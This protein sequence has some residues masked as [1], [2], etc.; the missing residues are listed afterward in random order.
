[1]IKVEAVS[2]PTAEF[3]VLS[4]KVA[5]KSTEVI[6]LERLQNFSK[7]V[8]T[9]LPSLKD[10]WQEEGKSLLKNLEDC[11]GRDFCGMEPDE[12]GYFDET[13]T[14]AR[15]SQVRL[16]ELLN[17]AFEETQ[18]SKFL[19]EADVLNSFLL[20]GNEKLIENSLKQLMAK[21]ILKDSLNKLN[22]RSSAQAIMI[23]SKQVSKEELVSLIEQSLEGS[24]GHTVISVFE[25]L[26]KVQFGEEGFKSIVKRVC[27]LNNGLPHNWQAIKSI[28]NKISKD[29]GFS[30][31]VKDVCL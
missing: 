16:L 1:M 11:Q 4:Q 19:L 27:H 15:K 24:N 8:K 22:G 21:G 23:L 3:K 28:S 29:R 5:K 30:I 26:D 14:H 6:L 12:D 10:E 2:A 17:L 20:S 13:Q 9:I 18:N 25:I 7:N 31:T